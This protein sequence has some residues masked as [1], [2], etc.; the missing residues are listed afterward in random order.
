MADDEYTRPADPDANTEDLGKPSLAALPKKIGHY[1]LLEQIGEGGFAIVY[2]AEQTEPVKRTVALKLIKPGMDSKQVMARFEAERQVLALMDHPNIAKVFDAGITTPEAGS[3]LFF[4]MEYVAGVPLTDHCDRHRLTVGERLELFRTICHAVQHAHQK[5]IIHR[6]LKPSNILVSVKEDKA[7][8]KIIDF[9]VAKALHQKLTERT[10]FTELGQLIGTPEYM[11]PEQAEM[12]AQNVDTRSDIYSLGV[13]LYELLTGALPFD[14]HMLRDAAFAEIQRVIR[15]E[16][17]P[18]PST[19]LSSLGDKSTASAK[20]RQLDTRALLRE[21]RG[22]LDWIVMK[23]LEKDRTRRYQTSMG[24]ANDIGRH[25]VHEPVS[26]SPPS[27]AYKLKKFV[28]RNLALSLATAVVTLSLIAGIVVSTIF[29]IGESIANDRSQREAAKA[30][31][32]IA[33]LQGMFSSLDPVLTDPRDPD[34]T[35]RKVRVAD[36]LDDTAQ[37]L[38]EGTVENQEVE[39]ALR[40]A[41]GASYLGL[42]LLDDAEEHLQRAHSLLATIPEIHK[43]DVAVTLF[44]YAWL[45]KERNRY[46]EAESMMRESLSLFTDVLGDKHERIAETLH[47]LGLIRSRMGEYEDA[48]SLLEQSRE[49]WRRLAGPSSRG[50]G[51]N[52]AEIGRILVR[53]GDL[54]SAED[55]LRRALK[56]FTGLYPDDH[57]YVGH[58][59]F[60]LSAVLRSRNLLEDAEE[61]ARDAIRIRRRA[62]GPDHGAVAAALIELALVQHAQEKYDDALK[63]VQEAL[64]IYKGAYG[65]SHEFIATA[66][67]LQ[68]IVLDDSGDSQAAADI[69]HRA[70]DIFSL[71][72]GADSWEV[73]NARLYYGRCLVRLERYD[74]A[75][76]QMLSAYDGFTAAGS[77]DHVRLV[78]SYLTDLYNKRDEPDEAAIWRARAE[79]IELTEDR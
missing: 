20:C 19:R 26:A 11:S 36:L 14:P 64:E 69:Y 35:G 72:K 62:Y 49:M 33:L 65:D 51:E 29:A 39:A 76:E 70:I 61:F 79:S 75:E 23:A 12:T 57:A 45:H 28:R 71:K 21:L 13:L 41:L 48:I 50:V 7:V 46:G 31:E 59:K 15:E 3:R 32:V 5:G 56:I 22:D 1:R 4:V 52:Y 27:A 55:N 73:A 6:D 8:P 2:L 34:N 25:L 60:S 67:H 16:D 30:R 18:K 43:L 9:G 37:Q 42:G 53:K 68:A 77:M 66:M 47:Y 40:T 54:K 58:V 78:A 74:D 24:L 38:R 44:H 63:S 17:P 10:L